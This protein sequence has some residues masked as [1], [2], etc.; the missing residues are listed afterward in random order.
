MLLTFNFSDSLA[1]ISTFN[2]ANQAAFA[3]FLDYLNFQQ[4]IFDGNGRYICLY[5]FL[6]LIREVLYNFR[7]KN[8]YKCPTVFILDDNM[9]LRSIRYEFYQVARNCMLTMHMV[10][11]FN[12]NN[13]TIYIDE[14][15]FAELCISSPLPIVLERNSLRT[16]PIPNSTISTMEWSLELPDPIKYQWEGKNAV[17]I[18]DKD[19]NKFLI[20]GW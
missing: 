15:G 16:T 9:P 19:K 17:I 8:E 14:I 11:V 13:I 7:L 18:N 5:L 2:S 10:Y 4:P 12:N 6:L 20:K 1:G 3:K